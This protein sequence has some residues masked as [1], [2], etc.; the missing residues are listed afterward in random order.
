MRRLNS[1]GWN[2]SLCHQVS[3]LR[4]R[5][6]P[7]EDGFDKTNKGNS[8]CF[9][10]RANSLKEIPH[11]FNQN[12]GLNKDQTL[13]K[14]KKCCS[15]GGHVSTIVRRIWRSCVISFFLLFFSCFRPPRLFWVPCHSTLMSTVCLGPGK[16]S[17][18][19]V[20]MYD[21][22]LFSTLFRILFSHSFQ[23]FL[24]L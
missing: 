16:Y 8:R 9:T 7:T 5:K 6:P 15:S 3:A 11:F 18:R 22:N 12:G 19:S 14:E 20:H 23:V 10:E 17:S 4:S 2:K 1:S 13:Q 24:A 21:Y